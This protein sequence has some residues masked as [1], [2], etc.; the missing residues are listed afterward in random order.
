MP[1]SC[2][3]SPQEEMERMDA[4]KV[5]VLSNLALVAIT[6]GDCAEAVKYCD[7]ALRYDDRAAKVMFRWVGECN[8]LK[9]ILSV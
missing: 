1:E 9:V 8:L 6:M 7:R 5:A 4:L 3:P 2:I